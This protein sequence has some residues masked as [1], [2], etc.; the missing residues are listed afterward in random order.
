[1]TSNPLSARRTQAAEPG[2]TI[3]RIG[4]T[5]AHDLARHYNRTMNEAA[6]RGGAEWF[7][8]SSGSVRL[9]HRLDWQ[10]EHTKHLARTA[11]DERQR[12]QT[13]R[14]YPVQEAAE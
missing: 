9:G 11:E 5:Y 10:A 2:P 13:R 3:E 12:M 4:P 14:T 7:V 6:L 8:D 1:M